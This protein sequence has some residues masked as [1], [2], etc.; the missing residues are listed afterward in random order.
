MPTTVARE[1]VH[2]VAA[3]GRQAPGQGPWPGEPTSGSY[4]F[5]RIMRGIASI[6]GGSLRRPP[7]TLAARRRLIP[8]SALSLHTQ[9]KTSNRFLEI[10]IGSQRW[11]AGGFRARRPDPGSG[12]IR[13]PRS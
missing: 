8:V 6:M 10:V 12:D 4:S 5:R 2:R 11:R 7:G 3:W 1:D 13:A 9:L